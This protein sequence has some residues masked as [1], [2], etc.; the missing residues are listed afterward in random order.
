[1][2]LMYLVESLLKYNDLYI[3]E[4]SMISIP[5]PFKDSIQPICLQLI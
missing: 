4:K 1:M 5:S 2:I 3:I